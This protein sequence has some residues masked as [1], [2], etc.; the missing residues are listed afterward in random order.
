M[1]NPQCSVVIPTI[2]RP[3]L[4]RAIE[5]AL[6]QEGVDVEV[7][8]AVSGDAQVAVK[9][10]DPRIRVVGPFGG[11]AN[12]ARQGGIAACSLSTVAMLD[13]DDEWS[14]SK[15][16]MQLAATDG[17]QTKNWLVSCEFTG[18]PRGRKTR[19][20]S[21]REEYV[22]EDPAEYLFVRRQVLRQ[23]HQLQTSTLVFPRELA[24]VVPFDSNVKLHQDWAWLLGLKQ[25]VDR[26]VIV[27]LNEPLVEYGVSEGF[28]I[29]R[30]SKWDES[31]AWASTYLGSLSPR[32]R[33]DFAAAV[34][35]NFARKNGQPLAVVRCL[36]WSVRNGRP[37]LASLV[38]A[39]LSIPFAAARGAK[40][41][42]RR[43]RPGRP[44]PESAGRATSAPV[45]RA[46]R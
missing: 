22:I 18:R 33:G 46:G 7:V 24:D 43:P 31:L 13:D 14:S 37:G 34:S 19:G 40:L 6:A 10:R 32:V 29:S 15:L 16:R 28:S 4:E 8:V 1:S 11:G 12:G 39:L 21:D 42:L 3:T 25:R 17:L 30:S 23:R 9:S 41:A 45:V 5:S 2:G 26:L 44:R 27:K 20:D 38:F 35:A 36:L